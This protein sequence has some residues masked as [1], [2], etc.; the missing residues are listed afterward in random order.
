MR[1]ALL[2]SVVVAA[3]CAPAAPPSRAADITGKITRVTDTSGGILLLVEAAETSGGAKAAETSGGAKAAVR[4]DG[5]T[6]IF[7]GGTS[8]AQRNA[9]SGD[10]VTGMEISVWFDGPAAMSY[11][12]QAKAATIFVTAAPAR[13]GPR[14][15]TP[16]R[17]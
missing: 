12:V 15:A 17:P 11:P 4:V 9:T 2:L 5:S 8:D 7:G 16:S 1:L 13:P 6:R 3:A 14:S 10:L